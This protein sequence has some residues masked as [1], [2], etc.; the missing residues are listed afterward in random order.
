MPGEE[1]FTLPP[2][3]EANQPKTPL[4]IEPPENQQ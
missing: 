2:Y 4:T 1:A 3:E